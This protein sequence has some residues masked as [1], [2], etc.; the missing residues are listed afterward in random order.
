M[1]T[2]REHRLY[3]TQREDG[4][5]L[6]ASVST[7][8]FCVSGPTEAEAKSKAQRAL[9]FWCENRGAPV[10]QTLSRT[11]SPFAPQS[12]ETIRPVAVCA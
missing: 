10:K 4:S 7:P 2:E 9:D 5:W 8:W 3:I 11:V 1:T 12:V 6:A